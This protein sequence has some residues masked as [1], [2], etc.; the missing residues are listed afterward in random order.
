MRPLIALLAIALSL[1]GTA[2]ADSLE[3]AAAALSVAET[4][5]QVTLTVSR[6]GTGVGAVTVDYASAD[7]TAAAGADY[8]AASGTLSWADGDLTPKP[9]QIAVATDALGEGDETFTVALSNPGGGA[10]LGAADTATVTVTNVDGGS[11]TLDTA[12]LTVDETATSATFQVSRVGGTTGAVSVSYATA[13]GSATAGQ[14]YD[15]RS[16]TLSWGDG[17]GGAQTVS[18]PLNDDASIEGDET[19]TLTLSNPSGAVIGTPGAASVTITDIETGV[20]QFTSTTLS[21]AEGD[22]VTLTVSRTGGTTGAASV[23]YATA[24]GS[25]VPGQDYTATSGTLS[26]SDG[27]SGNK[28]FDLTLLNDTD[29]ES[30][31][32]VAI[33]LSNASGGS[34]GSDSSATVTI[35]NTDIELELSSA[36][37]SSLE[38]SGWL[39]ITVARNG[40]GY[41]AASVRYTVTAGSATTGVDYTGDASGTLDWTDGDAG[42]RTIALQLIDD[43]F[44]ESPETVTVAIASPTGATLGTTTSATL[45]ILDDD[46]DFTPRLTLITP[47]AADGIAQPDVVDLSEDSP[48]QAGTTI[49]SLANAL[50]VVTSGRMSFTQ[51][52]TTGQLNSPVDAGSTVA[53]AP[54]RIEATAA[55]EQPGLYLADNGELRIIT[56]GGIVIVCLPTS[57]DY[58][59]LLTAV[60]AEGLAEVLGN[61][62]GDVSVPANAG[63]A[64]LVPDDDGELIIPPSWFER[65]MVRPSMVVEPVAA[66]TDADSTT[67]TTT[68]DD[69]PGG[70]VTRAHPQIRGLNQIVHN[71]EIEDELH[72]QVLHPAVADWDALSTAVAAMSNFQRLT[73]DINGVI[74]VV[75][76]GG[77]VAFLPG[78]RVH[79]AAPPA[80]GVTEFR[81]QPDLNGDGLTD[82]LVIYPNGDYQRAFRVIP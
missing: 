35:R 32:T 11:L 41:G 39:Y 14:D 75:F 20:L 80:S 18:I 15:A 52:S 1:A 16:G 43:D 70:I 66:D 19:F 71:V 3:F 6:A 50:D 37:A 38:G 22:T 53:L 31:E 68:T 8:T 17:V 69:E 47:P 49:L 28:T 36:A 55:G 61:A 78:Y 76:T 60:I 23:D 58:S 26:W 25:A 44:A 7:G 4:D 73:Q 46:I 2:H 72:E 65:V 67:T 54:V 77:S 27:E 30:D 63:A 51:D 59:A 12:A 79:R 29:V 82:Y 21:G 10:T 33:T 48:L 34:I 24:S 9:I 56:D 42:A 81:P 5:G 64:P 13:D 74:R 40:G 62:H 57:A 45:T